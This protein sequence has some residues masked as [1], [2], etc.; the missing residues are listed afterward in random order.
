MSVRH[1]SGLFNFPITNI[2][3]FK[4]TFKGPWYNYDGNP[5]ATAGNELSEMI[6][7]KIKNFSPDPN[8]PLSDRLGQIFDNFKKEASE[9]INPPKENSSRPTGTPGSLLYK[10]NQDNIR[11]KSNAQKMQ[12]YP[13]FA[14]CVLTIKS[15]V[16]SFRD[17][18]MSLYNASNISP[19]ELVTVTQKNNGDERFFGGRKAMDNQ[20]F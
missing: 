10:I 19:E 18:F 9:A 14:T 2:T 7:Q 4:Y 6:S 5:L 8:K 20:V 12:A 1:V 11:I 16:P 15:A 3:N 13:S 17:D